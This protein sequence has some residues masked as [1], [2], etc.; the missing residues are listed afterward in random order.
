MA[1]NIYMMIEEK[2]SLFESHKK[3]A[4]SVSTTNRRNII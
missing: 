2:K 3:V 4:V 1:Y